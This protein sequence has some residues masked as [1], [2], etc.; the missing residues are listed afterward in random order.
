MPADKV[1][2][3]RIANN[4]NFGPPEACCTRLP[5]DADKQDEDAA[6]VLPRTSLRLLEK[7]KKA[8]DT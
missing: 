6:D 8:K 2:L 1:E 3:T 4:Y 5:S 7:T